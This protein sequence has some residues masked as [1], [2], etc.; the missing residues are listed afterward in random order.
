VNNIPPQDLR[1][2]IHSARQASFAAAAHELGTSPAYISN[3]IGVLER[4]L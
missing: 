4:S 2:F 3:R 1:V